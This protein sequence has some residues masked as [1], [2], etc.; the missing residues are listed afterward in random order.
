MAADLLFTLIEQQLEVKPKRQ[1]KYEDLIHDVVAEYI[2]RL[3]NRGHIP[4]RFLDHL[5]KDL[6]E[7]AWDFLRKKTYGAMELE[8]YQEQK[9]TI[10]RR[11]VKSE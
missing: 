3:M 2:F 4:H 10:R 9:K 6:K 7:E 5:E 8:Q 1:R 11:R